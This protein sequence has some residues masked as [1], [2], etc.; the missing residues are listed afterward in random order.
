MLGYILVLYLRVLAVSTEKE[1]C[2]KKT[3]VFITNL[4]K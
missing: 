2:I 1:D 3:W 4:V